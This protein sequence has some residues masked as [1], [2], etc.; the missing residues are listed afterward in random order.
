MVCVATAA[1]RFLGLPRFK[2]SLLVHQRPS[3]TSKQTESHSLLAS[4]SGAQHLLARLLWRALAILAFV[5]AIIGAFLPVM[6]TVPFLLLA[7]WAAGKGW[8]RFEQ[9]LLQHRWFGPAIMRWRVSGAVSRKAKWLATFMLLASAL[10]LQVFTVLHLGLRLAMPLL[11][12]VVL[13]WLWLRPE[14]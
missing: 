9:W 14:H 10:L 4:R 11:F 13:T 6:P 7:A 3:V 12:L 2:G 1:L 5:L 8:P